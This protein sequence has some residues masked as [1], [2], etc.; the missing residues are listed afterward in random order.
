MH[1]CLREFRDLLWLCPWLEGRWGVNIFQVPRGWGC[2]FSGCIGW[3][4]NR[5]FVGGD[6]FRRSWG[7]TSNKIRLRCCCCC[8]LRQLVFFKAIEELLRVAAYLCA[9]TGADMILYFLPVSAKNLYAFN[10]LSVFFN[11]PTACWFPVWRWRVVP[12]I[13]ALGVVVAIYSVCS[14]IFYVVAGGRTCRV[15]YGNWSNS[16]SS[17]LAGWV[18]ETEFGS[19]RVRMR[20]IL[21][22]G[23]AV[24]WLNSLSRATPHCTQLDLMY[25]FCRRRHNQSILLTRNWSS[26]ND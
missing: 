22:Y 21:H 7:D 17:C 15:Y 25:L 12:S 2:E 19:L 20:R 24:G 14:C 8:C 13:S 1:W 3:G 18:E 5:L 11:R 10:E 9:W 26:K 23:L 6:S 4:V 16:S